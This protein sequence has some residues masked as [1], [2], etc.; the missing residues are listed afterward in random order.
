MGKGRRVGGEGEA[1]HH[2][3][4]LASSLDMRDRT[5]RQQA[6]IGAEG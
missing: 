3:S 1:Y 5:N 4:R 2:H 6:R